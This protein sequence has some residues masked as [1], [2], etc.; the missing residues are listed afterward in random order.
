MANEENYNPDAETKAETTPN[1]EEKK[2]SILDQEETEDFYFYVNL[3]N[4]FMAETAEDPEN[5]YYL[6]MQ[7]TYAEKCNYP[8]DAPICFMFVGYLAGVLKGVEIKCEL[9]RLENSHKE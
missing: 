6:K 2:P 3:F 1:V 4:E 9:D 8:K 7:R 5:D